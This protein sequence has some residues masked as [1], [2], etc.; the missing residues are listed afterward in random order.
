[1]NFPSDL[2][3]EQIDLYE[4][5]F[6]AGD[7]EQLLCEWEAHRMYG[8]EDGHLLD[9]G[10]VRQSIVEGKLDFATACLQI[11]PDRFFDLKTPLSCRDEEEL[12]EI[13]FA[14][15]RAF[16]AHEPPMAERYH[17]MVE[18]MVKRG[19]DV[20]HGMRE[21]ASWKLKPMLC[22]IADTAGCT[23]LLRKLLPLI[24]GAEAVR[25]YSDSFG[26]GL[27]R[28]DFH[29]TLLHR[30]VDTRDA[31]MARF[32]V[33]EVGIDANTVDALGRT[34]FMASLWILSHNGA[35]SEPGKLERGRDLVRGLVQL[36]MDI[37]HRDNKRETA[38]VYAVQDDNVEAARLLLELGADSAVRDAK[39]STLLQLAEQKGSE[40]V[41][42]LFR[43]ME[44][45]QMLDGA[46][47]DDDAP[48]APS[49]SSGGM[50]L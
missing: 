37:E 39:G 36:G 22:R 26:G 45:E 5:I 15:L 47:S 24:G 32:L 6:A 19:W 50:T 13:V 27:L 48:T 49:R 18:L 42:R 7:G 41:A 29:H 9:I 16:A 14:K 2:K 40:A 12:D 46:M 23:S 31:E 43:S 44:M 20:T 8:A 35:A 1:M 11:L 3:D 38:L 34:A 30:A 33:A 28:A 25:R 4:A 17:P 21:G 10:H